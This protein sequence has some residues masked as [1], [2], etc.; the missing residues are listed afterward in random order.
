MTSSDLAILVPV[1]GRPELISP[2]MRSIRR[3]VPNAEVIFAVTPGDIAV[4][5]VSRT[6]MPVV[7]VE[8]IWH[9]DYARKINQ[10]YLATNRSWIFLGATDLEFHSRW[11]QNA[12]A[13]FK[14]GIG[15][16]GTND[17]GN[18]RVMRG[19]TATHSLVSREYI[20]NHGTIDGKPG[21]ILFEGYIHEF[22]D[23]EFVGTARKRNAFAMALNS[24][25]EHLHPNFGKGAIDDMYRDQN[26]RMELSF[27]L[28]NRRK[29]LWS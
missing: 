3:T 9:G 19:D 8:W 13:C 5:E 4:E 25:V 28:F 23:D 17:L 12:M 7:E 6:G 11:Y 27:P 18:P 10:A 20:E 2:L 26:R 24:H 15:V 16:I 22:V 14:P 29:R 1:L 21:P